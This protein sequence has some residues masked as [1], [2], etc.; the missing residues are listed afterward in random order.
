MKITLTLSSLF[1]LSIAALGQQAEGTFKPVV[2]QP[3]K[4]VVWVPTP[5]E[6][7]D[8]MLDVAKVTPQDYVI[9]LGSGDGR[10]VISAARR[11]AR[12]LGVEWNQEMVD[13]S[14]RVAGEAGLSG[15]G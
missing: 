12:A 10:N 4:D 3:G 5:Q 6:T 7:V 14:K 15:K 8:R 9:D 1:L 13:L 11:G 2:G